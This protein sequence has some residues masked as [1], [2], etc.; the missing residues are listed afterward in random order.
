MALKGAATM[1]VRISRAIISRPLKPVFIPRNYD[2]THINKDIQVNP[3]S[4]VRFYLFPSIYRSFFAHN[5]PSIG[6]YQQNLSNLLPFRAALNE[7]KR[8]LFFAAP[9]SSRL[10]LGLLGYSL[11][12]QNTFD[13]HRLDQNIN[14]IGDLL[15]KTTNMDSLHD[16]NDQ[17]NRASLDDFELGRLLGYGC[18]AAV[19][20]AR[21]RRSSERTS[22]LSRDFS[23]TEENHT[24]SDIEI[25][26]RQSS[27]I[28][29]LYEDTFDNEEQLNEL[30]L[31][32]GMY[33]LDLKILYFLFTNYSN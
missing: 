24:D 15:S 5:G 17:Y 12:P 28:S 22:R 16:E 7:I 19:Y 3:K 21:L 2:L 4:P 14:K 18:N 9:T 27:T 13:H 6:H 31:K 25:L 30:T 8:R 26:S 1:I 10:I 32:E 23:F 11:L 29:S 33:R 20:E